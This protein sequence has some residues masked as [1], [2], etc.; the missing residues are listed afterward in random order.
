MAKPVL[1]KETP[2]SM[3]ELKHK[4]ENI[5]KRDGEL[6]FRANKTEEYLGQF[7]EMSKKKHDDFKKA[8]E[9]LK[10]SRLKEEHIIKIIDTMPN[11]TE[12]LKVMLQGYLLSLTQEQ[13]KKIID[14]VQEYKN[15]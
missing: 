6:N 9:D 15:G 14:T 5:K 7:V 3:A 12:E 13:L 11:S 10:I 8:L 4:L 2:I 1:L